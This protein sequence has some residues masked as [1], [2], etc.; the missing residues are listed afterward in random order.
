LLANQRAGTSEPVFVFVHVASP[1]FAY[2][3]KGKTKVALPYAVGRGIADMVTKA[4]DKWR[5]QREA[6]L[7]HASAAA[8]R[9][10][11]ME[12]P[13]K[14]MTIKAAA[15]QIMPQAYVKAAGGIGLANARQVMYAARPHI[16]SLTSKPGFDDAYFTQTLLPDYQTEHPVETANWDVV[17][18]DRGHFTEPHTGRAIGLGTL[19]VRNYLASCRGPSISPTTV[20]PASVST[21]GPEG[22]YRTAL[23]VEKEGFTPILE[24]AAIAERFDIAPMSTKGMSVTAARQLIDGLAAMGVRVFVLRDF[25]ITGF[26][27]QKTFTGDGRRHAF[28]NKLDYVDLGLRLADVQRLGLQAEP[29]NLFSK[30]SQKPLAERRKTL[31]ERLRINGAREDEIA[32]LTTDANGQAGAIGKRVEL[33]ALTSDE[34]IAFVEEKLRENDVAKVVPDAATLARTF[35]AMVHGA[36]ARAAFAATLERVNAEPVDVPPD[37][38]VNV[39]DWL[40]A[41][42]TG[43]WDDAIAAIANGS[44]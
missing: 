27:I 3:D 36:Q 34:F 29:V 38:A 9:R 12:K 2:V 5:R 23:F 40:A 21:S 1:R 31:I 13:D 37:L 42:P 28:K 15:Y 10:E 26:S 11:F 43:T 20:V 7:R 32:F 39:C 19:A 33:N 8:R 24:R 44:R 22:R 16:L 35:T 30:D 18:D 14:P 25:D 41:H 4:T 6:E 17:Y